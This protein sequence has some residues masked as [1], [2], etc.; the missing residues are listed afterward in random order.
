MNQKVI[1]KNNLNVTTRAW[2]SLKKSSIKFLRVILKSKEPD[3]LAS[4][5][6][7]DAT[8]E[9]FWLI[10]DVHISRRKSVI[11]NAQALVFF[12][13]SRK[14]CA[15]NA[16]VFAGKRWWTSGLIVRLN[17]KFNCELSAK[18]T[19]LS[20]NP[21]KGAKR[22]RRNNMTGDRSLRGSTSELNGGWCGKSDV[23]I[24]G[25]I[26]ELIFVFVEKRD[27]SAEYSRDIKYKTNIA[28]IKFS[29]I[30][31]LHNYII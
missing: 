10:R 28:N 13:S 2:R 29:G 25:K 31:N 8:T 24:G 12:R 27:D 7:P 14:V 1:V 3:H 18:L 26:N 22:I 30:I 6:S 20:S 17:K 21:R 23:M 19:C 9:W 4:I 16:Y 11:N 5:L 15:R